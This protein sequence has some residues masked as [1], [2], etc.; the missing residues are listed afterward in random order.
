MAD[1]IVQLKDRYDDTVN[2]Y[3]VT[4]EAVVVDDEGT[5]LTDKLTSLHAAVNL[6]ANI[7]SLDIEYDSTDRIIILSHGGV[8]LGTVDCNQFIIQSS[9]TAAEYVTEGQQGEEGEF[10][11]LTFGTSDIIYINLEPIVLGAL[12]SLVGRIT[13]LEERDVWLTE[14]EYEAL[15]VAE[16]IDPNKVYHTYEE[17]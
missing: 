6:K 1:Q 3:P 15:V 13:A 12:D 2:Q 16:L 7:Q 17:E 11:K 8:T 14:E 4:L 10:L 5:S 9:L